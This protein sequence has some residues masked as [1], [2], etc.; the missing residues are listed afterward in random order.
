MAEPI[1]FYDSASPKNI[2]TGVY[3]AV[4]VNGRYAWPEADVDRM[5]KVIRISVGADPAWAAHARCIDV[6]TGAAT[7]EQ[8]MA[9][10]RERRNF[11]YDDATVYCD[12]STLVALVEA[13][14]HAKIRPPY[15]W[16]ATLD[17]TQD[18]AG[19]WAVQYQGGPH[20]PYDLSVLHGVDN[21]HRP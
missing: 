19:A 6:E 1:R 8:A 16:V 18:V 13:F 4:Y 7:L 20:A 9:F 12:R 17:Q 21:F 15:W 3:A 10:V 14:E 2:P 11:G 5:A